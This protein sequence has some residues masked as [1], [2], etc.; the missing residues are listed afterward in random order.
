MKNYRKRHK[1]MQMF[2]TVL[3]F[4][5]ALFRSCINQAYLHL[6]HEFES[7]ALREAAAG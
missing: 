2:I 6:Q 1:F 7:G 3:L 4:S 5:N